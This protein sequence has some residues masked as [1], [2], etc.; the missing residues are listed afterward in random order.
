MRLLFIL[1]Y[2]PTEIRVRPYNLLRQLVSRGHDITLVTP[3]ETDGE[4]QALAS[5]SDKGVD[6]RAA[7]LSKWRVAWNMLRSIPSGAPLQASYVETPALTNMITALCEGDERDGTRVPFDVAHVEHLRGVRFGLHVERMTR[8]RA[9]RLPVVWDSV[10]C[11]SY[12]FGQATQAS[13]SWRARLMARAETNK[14]RRFEGWLLGKL[15]PVLVTSMADKAAFEEML[16]LG[17]PSPVRVLPNG[18]DLNRFQPPSA[19]RSTGTVIF[20][21]KMSYHANV[22]AALHLAHDIMPGVWENHP[23]TRLWIVGSSPPREIRELARE[24]GSRVEVTGFVEDLGARLGQATVA[25]APLVYGAG[26][27]NKVLE[28][29]ACGTPVVASSLA[30]AALSVTQGQ[31]CLI[32]ADAGGFAQA[33]VRVL[34]HPELAATLGDSGRR[35]VEQHHRWD[36]VATRLEGLYEEAIRTSAK[37]G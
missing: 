16:P 20:S 15:D 34:E 25:A 24:S 9:H 4:L 14:T 35:Y 2:A 30:V 23:E 8:G 6:V 26:I 1:P 19:K 37:V 22:T 28:A 32:A 33:L 17:A 12:L 36:A 5:W 7:A 3:W 11:I 18:V 27:Q 10:D 13:D 29:M 31:D 21:G